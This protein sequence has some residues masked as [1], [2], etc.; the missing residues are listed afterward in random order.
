MHAS[1]N[2]LITTYQPSESGLIPDRSAHRETACDLVGMF[3][4]SKLSVPIKYPKS[5]RGSPIVAFSQSKTANKLVFL[6]LE[7]SML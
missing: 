5:M 1:L 2:L 6:P 3:L 4:F 7:K